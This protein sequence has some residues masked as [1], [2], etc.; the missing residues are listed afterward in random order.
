MCSSRL[1]WGSAPCL[2]TLGSRLTEELPSWILIVMRERWLFR[3][4]WTGNYTGQPRSNTSPTLTTHKTPPNRKGA[5]KCNHTTCLEDRAKSAQWTR[6]TLELSSTLLSPFMQI[7]HLYTCVYRYAERSLLHKT[8]SHYK[9]SFPP[10]MSP[11][12]VTRAKPPRTA[13]IV[14]I[15]SC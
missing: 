3:G 7:I 12:T 10:F 13:G 11:P 6:N 15:H 8:G 14:L 4:S 9:Q 2:L 5:R 1:I